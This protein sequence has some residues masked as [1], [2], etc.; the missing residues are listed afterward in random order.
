[1]NKTIIQPA[2][3]LSREQEDAL[4]RF[5]EAWEQG[6]SPDWEKYL[7]VDSSETFLLELLHID[8]ERKLKAGLAARVETYLEAH[9][10]LAHNDEALIDL[11]MAEYRLR[12][13][14]EPIAAADFVHRFRHLG[15]RLDNRLNL[16]SQMSP[17]L[18]NMALPSIA[19]SESAG[20]EPGQGNGGFS[21]TLVPRVPN[22]VANPPSAEERYVIQGKLGE[23]GMGAV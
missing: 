20:S 22:V 7:A 13:Q 19:H 15:T 18:R 17:D 23:G 3:E 6:E 4:L 9:P 12:A 14:Y 11:I 16:L 8:L 5:D 2:A 1:M 10:E 21:H